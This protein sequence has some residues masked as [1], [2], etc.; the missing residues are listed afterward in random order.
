M[1]CNQI[2]ASVQVTRGHN[3]ELM[4]DLHTKCRETQYLHYKSSYYYQ[5]WSYAI[6]IPLLIVNVTVAAIKDVIPSKATTAVMV[7]TGIL[8]GLKNMFKLERRSQFHSTQANGYSKL[9]NSVEIK[10]GEYDKEAIKMY[11]TYNNLNEQKESFVPEKIYKKFQARKLNLDSEEFSQN[12][13]L[14]SGGVPVMSR[15]MTPK[16]NPVHSK[17]LNDI[18][19]GVG[20]VDMS[21]MTPESKSEAYDVEKDVFTL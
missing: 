5:K 19:I 9:A 17:I 21:N 12:V 6:D 20:V 16:T 13:I 15:C 4:N 10:L 11:G 8:I 7:I 1:N 2:L 14:S 3:N 18:E